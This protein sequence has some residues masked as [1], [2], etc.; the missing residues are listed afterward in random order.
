MKIRTLL[1]LRFTLI[2]ASILILFA[3]V[4]YWA[5]RYNREEEFYS[6]LTK[7]AITKANL[8]LEAEV[9]SEIMQNIYRNNRQT[10]SE[11]EVA[12]YD[13]NFALVYHDAVEIDKVKESEALLQKV[14]ETG[15]ARFYI[16]DWQV[17]ALRYEHQGKAYVM[18]AAAYDQYGYNKLQYLLQ[19]LFWTGICALGFICG[20]GYFFARKALRPVS[21]MAAQA[22]NIS[23]KNLDLRLPN[24]GG[25]DEL[26]ELAQIFNT[27]LDRLE[28]SFEAQK[29]FVANVSHELRTPLFAIIAELEW[30]ASQPCDY[31]QVI[32]NTL[33]DA[34]RIIRLS[35]SLLNLAKAQYDPSEISFKALRVDEVL[36]DA[37]QAV[38]KAHPS[39]KVDI[40][41]AEDPEEEAA[42]MLQ[43]NEYLLMVAFS[44]LIDNA[45]K[46]SEDHS[47]RVRIS[48]QGRQLG[49]SFIDEGLGIAPE[50]VQKLF[51]PFYRGNNASKAQGSG[52]GLYLVQKIIDLHQ[53]QLRLESRPAQGTEVVLLLPSLAGSAAF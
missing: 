46:F 31:Q 18:T 14:L 2:T 7:E 35:N 32:E 26:A 38:L 1:T 3:I 23:A 13:Q 15:T 19:R 33:E 42:M 12:I 29:H 41:F 30:A 53:G 51:Q 34:R 45:C 24:N 9:S 49:L 16:D 4:I 21:L 28:Q 20:A 50:E 52:I 27:M 5:A 8:F 10:L 43:G 25:K 36:L 17:V 44:N 39:Y 47:C 37:C 11:V 48:A 40:A 6:L 22:A